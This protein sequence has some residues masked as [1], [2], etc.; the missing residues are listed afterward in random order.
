[1]TLWSLLA[2]A[3]GGALGTLGR[4]GADLAVVDL[5]LGQHWSTLAVN[6]VGTTAL[7]FVVGHG[8]PRWSPALR[9]GLGVGMLGS[10]T[11]M[12][13]VSLLTLSGPWTLSLGYLALTLGAALALGWIGFR[14][15]TR[16]KSDHTPRSTP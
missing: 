2:V 11:T 15:G 8:L 10:Y 9:D 4:L 1:M 16:W 14:L 3:I 5:P 7:G 6:L 12:S 13:G